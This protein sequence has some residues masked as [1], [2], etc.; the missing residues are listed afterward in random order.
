MSITLAFQNMYAKLPKNKETKTKLYDSLADEEW[1]VLDDIFP[2]NPE[3]GA[4][5]F[6]L[7]QT[8]VDRVVKLSIGFLKGVLNQGAFRGVYKETTQALPQRK[9]KKPTSNK[10]TKKVKTTPTS[11]KTTKGPTKPP[12]KRGRKGRSPTKGTGEGNKQ[13][14]HPPYI[15]TVPAM[16]QY[17]TPKLNT[18]YG[19]KLHHKYHKRGG[20][21]YRVQKA[22]REILD[23]HVRY[24]VKEMARL[25]VVHN[26]KSVA[27]LKQLY[28]LKYQ[29]YF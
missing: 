1:D 26:P 12:S 18:E 16:K 7:A 8:G 15:V 27:E 22:A 10:E 2:S 28:V 23:K 13:K 25:K 9:R 21:R 5:S 24:L 29:P 3:G 19:K 4:T 20:R 6:P 14:R 17:T 11:A